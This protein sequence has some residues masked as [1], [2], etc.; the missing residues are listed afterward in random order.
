[1]KEREKL[2]ATVAFR[3]WMDQD[4]SMPVIF[5]GKYTTLWHNGFV[6]GAHTL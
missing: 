5:K 3:D 2:C 4:L 6:E 1:M